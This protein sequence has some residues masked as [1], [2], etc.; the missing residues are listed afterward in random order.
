MAH[1]TFLEQ[2]KAV[3]EESDQEVK[4]RFWAFSDMMLQGQIEVP[5]YEGTFVNP[6]FENTCTDE[7]AYELTVAL[8]NSSITNP[9]CF[10]LGTN[11]N[12]YRSVV[13]PVLKE[14]P[15]YPDIVKDPEFLTHHINYFI[16]HEGDH[17]Q[18]AINTGRWVAAAE[19]IIVRNYTD[20]IVPTANVIPVPLAP[21]SS[22]DLLRR[23]FYTIVSAARYPSAGD[24]EQMKLLERLLPQK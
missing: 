10:L 15:L 4:D 20:H 24:R 7:M 13:A 1:R 19:V 17:A 22:I 16:N 2:I 5:V 21:I 6:I 3:D 18:A 12:R 14:H 11:L 9:T 23:D 8:I